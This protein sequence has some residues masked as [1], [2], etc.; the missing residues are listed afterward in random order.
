L[1]KQNEGSSKKANYF[2]CS[3]DTLKSV[4]QHAENAIEAVLQGGQVLGKVMSL[5]DIK[6]ERVGNEIR[7]I[8]LFMSI[9]MNL[10]EGLY[11][12]VIDMGFVLKEMG[13]TDF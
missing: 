13:E 10:L 9:I 7:N 2:F 6:K 5:V 11:L 4:Y 1:L 8:G 3:V 12:L